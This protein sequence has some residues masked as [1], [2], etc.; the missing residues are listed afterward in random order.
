M[1]YVI[2]RIYQIIGGRVALW[3]CIDNS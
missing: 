2:K 1:F 3:N